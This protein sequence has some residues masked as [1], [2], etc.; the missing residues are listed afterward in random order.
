MK[1]VQVVEDE[2]QIAQLLAS[3]LRYKGFEVYV[4]PNGAGALDQVAQ[5]RPDLVLLDVML[6]DIDGFEVCR[7]LRAQDAALPILMLTARNALAEK[8]AGLDCGADDYITKPFDFDELLARIR[9]G[10]RRRLWHPSS[11]NKRIIVG[12]IVIHLASRQVE[13]GGHVIALTRREYD[14]LEVLARNRGQVV[15]PAIIFSHVWDDDPDVGPEIL[16][17]YIH[18][19]RKKLNAYGQGNVIHSIRGVG[20]MLKALSEKTL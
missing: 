1:R 20:Y 2:P 8:V 6:P 13:R 16:K 17:V 14:L 9:A 12:D 10:L 4:V 3:G 7:R 11:S 5:L 15:T 18:S 19:L